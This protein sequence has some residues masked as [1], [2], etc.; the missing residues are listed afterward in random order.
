MPKTYTE[1]LQAHLDSNIKQITKFRRWKQKNLSCIDHNFIYKTGFADA[2][3]VVG[4]IQNPEVI[5]SQI[6][7]CMLVH[8]PTHTR[9]VWERSDDECAN[10]LL[11]DRPRHLQGNPYKVMTCLDKAYE[12]IF[13]EQKYTSIYGRCAPPVKDV[14]TRNKEWR[15]TL[16]RWKSKA[17]SVMPVMLPRLQCMWLKVCKWS[18]PAKY[19]SDEF[20]DEAILVLS[21]NELQNLD[22]EAL[23]ALDQIHGDSRRKWKFASFKK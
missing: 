17:G 4:S 8:Q 16:K 12:I 20:P 15:N 22:G 18:V 21:P 2:L 13:N 9:V 14:G 6:P 7:V 1:R 3:D 5:K 23:D 11:V 19:I 10:V